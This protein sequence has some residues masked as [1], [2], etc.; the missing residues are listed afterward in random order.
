MKQEENPLLEKNEHGHYIGKNPLDLD[1]EELNEAGHEHEPIMKSIRKKCLDCVCYQPKEVR[2]CVM[3]DCA[4]W[5]YRMGKNPFR[6]QISKSC[7]S[8]SNLN[9]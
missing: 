5:P 1:I 9:K 4:L 8:S 7:H 2:L 6:S 3:S